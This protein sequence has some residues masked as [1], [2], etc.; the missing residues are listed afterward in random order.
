MSTERP[1]ATGTTT[2]TATPRRLHTA[3]LVARGDPGAPSPPPR[4]AASAP[5]PLAPLRR[6]RGQRLPARPPQRPAELEPGHPP[7]RPGRGHG[8]ASARAVRDAR[9]RGHHRPARRGRSDGPG[10]GGPRLPRRRSVADLDRRA[11]SP[12]A[13]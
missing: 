1:T 2:A 7:G 11:R 10:V 3:R 6:V 5:T 13:G 9:A 12:T 8:F 4:G